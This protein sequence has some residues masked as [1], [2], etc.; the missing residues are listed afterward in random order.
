[1]KENPYKPQIKDEVSGVALPNQK[2]AIWQQGYS[3]GFDECLKNFAVNLK[4]MKELVD[5]GA[6]KEQ[7]TNRLEEAKNKSKE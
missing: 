4:L 3:A 7:I 1:M 5:Y 6:T 2:Y